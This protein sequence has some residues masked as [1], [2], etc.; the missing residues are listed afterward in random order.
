MLKQLILGRGGGQ[1][2]SVFVIL[3]LRSEFVS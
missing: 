3:L 1:V 2:V